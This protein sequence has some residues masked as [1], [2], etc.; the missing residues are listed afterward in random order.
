MGISKEQFVELIDKDGIG[1]ILHMFCDGEEWAIGSASLKKEP[2]KALYR[3]IRSMMATM[4]GRGMIDEK[5]WRT[6]DEE[7]IEIIRETL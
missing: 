4:C 1:F 7:I 5:Q 3:T 6:L 2:E